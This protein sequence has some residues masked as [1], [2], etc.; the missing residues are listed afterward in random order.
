MTRAG[1][2]FADELSR[3]LDRFADEWTLPTFEFEAVMAMETNRRVRHAVP[4]ED[5]EAD[6][7]DSEFSD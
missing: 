7:G 1:H 2:A 6:D 4:I 5:E 3:F